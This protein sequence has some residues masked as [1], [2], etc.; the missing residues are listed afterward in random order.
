MFSSTLLSTLHATYK[1]VISATPPP[2][3]SQGERKPVSILQVVGWD[4]GPVG[5]VRKISPPP[6]FDP[7]TVQPVT[8]PY[9][10][11]VKNDTGLL[12]DIG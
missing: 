10:G 3:Y 11:P 4:P 5:T 7:R 12:T 8:S 1:W 2:I 9:T 6:G